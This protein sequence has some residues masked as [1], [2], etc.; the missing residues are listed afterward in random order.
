MKSLEVYIVIDI[1]KL[2]RRL[3]Y[4]NQPFY[5]YR[6]VDTMITWI[7]CRSEMEDGRFVKVP[8]DEADTYRQLFNSYME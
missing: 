1:P 7:R 6:S 8:E 4:N 2:T 5:T 3:E